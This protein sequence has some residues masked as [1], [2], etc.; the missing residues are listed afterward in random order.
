MHLFYS[1]VT[2]LEHMGFVL[3]YVFFSVDMKILCD[4]RC[5]SHTLYVVEYVGHAI[6]LCLAF[7]SNM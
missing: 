4:S 6:E 7:R 2:S 5:T 1:I 3:V